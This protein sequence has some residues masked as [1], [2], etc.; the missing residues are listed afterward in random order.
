MIS[1]PEDFLWGTGTSAHQ[2]EGGNDAN[3]WW[4]WEHA[5]TQREPSGNACKHYELFGKDFDLAASLHHRAHRFSLEWSRI[6]P[7]EGEFSS[8]ELDHY[9]DVLIALQERKIEPVVTLH[10]FTTPLWLSRRGGWAHERAPELFTR[11]T[12][13]AVGHLGERVRF[14][15][16]INEPL[17]YSYYAYAAGIWPP[18]ERSFAR[19]QHVTAQFIRAHTAAYRLIHRL[20]RKR[21]W[22]RP[23][24]TIAK[25]L[26]PFYPCR[27]TIRNRLAC[28]LR[29]DRFNW[30]VLRH[31]VRARS[32]DIIGVNYYTRGVVDTRSWRWSSLLTGGCERDHH[33]LPQ[34][35]LGW[36][37]Y[38]EGLY[39]V[40]CAAGRFGLPLF[41]MENGICTED[42]LQRWDFIRRHLLSIARARQ[43]GV[44]V[45]GYLYWSLLDNFE[46]AEGFGPRF[47]LIEVD[48]AT[49]ERRIRESAL[50]FGEVCASGTVKAAGPVRELKFSRG[51]IRNR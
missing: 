21:G 6:E 24:V 23:M 46:W 4:A 9:R 18:G 37:I 11:F 34:N 36:D 13:K 48:Y 15:V 7:E 45:I 26:Q 31:L 39:E 32:L 43:R 22:Q 40:L 5:D 27:R 30:R 44:E 12:A 38:P 49:Q 50:R 17:V 28:A 1:F 20:Y 2:V 3:D 10:H 19:A 14:W 51:E 25:N 41:I 8:E 35:T 16:T 29:D 42:D 47:G 33:D